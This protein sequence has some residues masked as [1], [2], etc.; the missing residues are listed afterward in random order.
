MRERESALLAVQLCYS[1]AEVMVELVEAAELQ[2]PEG[3]A[4]PALFNL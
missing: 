3:S 4:S 1:D 2:R